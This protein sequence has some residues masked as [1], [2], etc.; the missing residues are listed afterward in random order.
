MKPAT[1]VAQAKALIESFEGRAEDF[2][3]RI[4]PA[5]LDPAGVNMAM[6]TDAVL[7]REWEPDGYTDAD[8]CRIYQYKTMGS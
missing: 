2:E 3:L 8:G 5:L 7:A 4:A 6:I 1:T